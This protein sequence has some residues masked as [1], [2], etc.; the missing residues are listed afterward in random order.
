MGVETEVTRLVNRQY[1]QCRIVYNHIGYYF[2][3]ESKL[4]D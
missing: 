4:E 3:V 2:E 1:V